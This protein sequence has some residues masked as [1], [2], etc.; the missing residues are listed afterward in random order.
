MAVIRMKEIRKLTP[1]ARNNRLKEYR[2]QLSEKYAQ[3]S[4]GGSIDDT[5]KITELRKT[6]ARFLTIMNEEQNE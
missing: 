4:A 1:E 6:I 3:L 2:A 5:G